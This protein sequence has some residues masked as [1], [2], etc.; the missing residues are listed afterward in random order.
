[1]MLMADP[2]LHSAEGL[3][4]LKRSRMAD[5]IPVTMLS[6]FLGTGARR[7][8][9][10]LCWATQRPIMPC[11]DAGVAWVAL[12]PLTYKVLF[13]RRQDHASE[14]SPG[15]HNAQDRVRRE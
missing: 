8:G 3:R 1:M 10:P 14:V 11:I 12:M 7:P 4:Y 9:R 2:G 15:E 5:P 13:P 6:G